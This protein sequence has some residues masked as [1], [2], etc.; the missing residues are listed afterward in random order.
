[1]PRKRSQP[2]QRKPR[3][4]PQRNRE[5]ILEV[6][7]DAFARSGAGTSL[8]DIAKQ[9][10]VGAGTLYRHF[11]TRDA[12]LEAVYRTEVEK[13][14]AAERKLAQYSS[15]HGGCRTLATAPA[16]N[17]KN[18]FS[19]VP[20]TARCSSTSRWRQA[21]KLTMSVAENTDKKLFPEN[22]WTSKSHLDSASP[23]RYMC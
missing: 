4:D 23:P 13:L 8:D 10:G 22:H 15:D 3:M 20:A 17:R 12:L 5:R 16:S 11:P 1:M 9:A 7:K 21:R 14:A 19:C 18:D 2:A 6:A